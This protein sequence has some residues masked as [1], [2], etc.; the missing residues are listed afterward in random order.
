MRWLAWVIFFISAQVQ[1][2]YAQC[3][4][5]MAETCEEANVLCSL[6]EMNG[7]TCQNNSTIPSPCAPLCSQGGLGDNTSWW[8]FVSAGG[9][10]TITLTVGSCNNGQGLEYG[11]WGDCICAEEI[12]C[13]SAP[14]IPANSMSTVNVTLKPCKTYYLWVDG[15]NGDVCNFTLNTSGGGPPALAPLG[16]I[17]N[18]PGMIIQPICEGACNVKFFVN[19]QPGGCVPTYVWTLDGNEVGGNSNEIQLDMPEEGDFAI[20]V[21]AYIG[22]PQSG[23]ICSQ[24]GPQCATAKV[25]RI[26]DKTGVPRF[27][28]WEEA[29]PGGYKWH[30]QRIYNSGT[31]REQFSDANCCKFDSIVE[32]TILEKPS[33]ERVYYISCDGKPYVDILGNKHNPCLF[34]SNVVLSKS[35]D[36]LKCDSSILLTAVKVD[37]APVWSM[38]CSNGMVELIPNVQIVKPCNAGETYEFEYKWYKKSDPTHILSTDDRLMVKPVSEEYCL[39]VIVKTQLE[40][41]IQFCSRTFCE[42]FDEGHAAPQC[43]FR[44]NGGKVYCFDTISDYWLDSIIPQQVK[45]YS[46]TVNGG[47]IISKTD[48]STIQVKW[49]LKPTDTGRVCVSYNTDCGTSCV[50]CLDVFMKTKIAGEDFEKRGLDAYLDAKQSPNGSWRLIRGPYP[51]VIHEPN[52]P[53]SKITAHNYGVYCFEWT[54]NDPNCILKDTICVNLHYYQQANPE[55]PHKIYFERAGFKSDQDN[56]S[57][58]LFTPNLISNTGQSFVSLESDENGPLNYRWF[59]IYGRA[60]FGN[61]V[62]IDSGIQRININA[63]DHEGMYYLVMKWNGMTTMRK[64]CV[65]N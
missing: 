23:S 33:P 55:Y 51:V 21:T 40:Y 50:K 9:N 2:L 65:I 60:V 59:D 1:I 31:Y 6:D 53:R 12:V 20:C 49:S 38:E 24:Q 58:L 61:D 63:P 42:S 39:E 54:I 37:Y 62:M 14:C 7:Y 52:N 41:E 44:L 8:G 45:F 16:K 26:L 46:W 27:I 3:T 34:Q 5:A 17:N 64:V 18:V 57:L 30:S 56:S 13:R 4:P 25:R 47:N 48:T 22:N 36:G 43:A 15:C 19:P 32:F 28:C 11:I 29:N 35:T 10:V